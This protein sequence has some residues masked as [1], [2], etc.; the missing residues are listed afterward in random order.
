[1]RT[2]AI[3]APGSFPLLQTT[4]RELAA[5]FQERQRSLGHPVPG[6]WTTLGA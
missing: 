6:Q 2:L 4:A 1:M 3:E 5:T